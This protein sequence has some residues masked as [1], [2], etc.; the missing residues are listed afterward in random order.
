V[1][2]LA[3]LGALNVIFNSCDAPAEKL[4]EA[5]IMFVSAII[6]DELTPTRDETP[7][8]FLKSKEYSAV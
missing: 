5:E 3:V 4:N 6:F 7:P 1:S 8:T 2:E